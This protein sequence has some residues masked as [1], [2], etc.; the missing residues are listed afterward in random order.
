M[1]DQLKQE[2][3]ETA[4]AVQ[5]LEV[6]VRDVHLRPGPSYPLS[7]LGICGVTLTASAVQIQT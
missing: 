6:L 4:L 5:K 3:Q 7:K 1:L 2:L